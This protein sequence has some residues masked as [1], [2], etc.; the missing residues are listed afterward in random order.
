MQDRRA[1]IIV[2]V[3]ALLTGSLALAVLALLGRAA[4]Q[5]ESPDFHG[6]LPM[7]GV[8]AIL[9]V[10]F[11]WAAVQA[12]RFRPSGI[13]TLSSGWVLFGIGGTFAYLFWF[14][15]EWRAQDAAFAAACVLVFLFGILVS[16]QQRFVAKTLA[17]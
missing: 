7:L 13:V 8:L 9:P 10:I 14:F 3:A 6:M 5:P 4:T 1:Q 11:I 16:R 17:E 12:W 2:R 15:T